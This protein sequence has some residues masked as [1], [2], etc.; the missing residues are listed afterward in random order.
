VK[1]AIVMSVLVAALM[2]PAVA[3]AFEGW[4]WTVKFAQQSLKRQ[5]VAFS[6]Q[7][8]RDLVTKALCIGIGQVW[9]NEGEIL[10]ARFRCLVNA[11]TP[12]G[13][14]QRYYIR[15]AVTGKNTFR[16]Q[17]FLGYA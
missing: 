17:K 11:I 8:G 5:G 3:Q 15:I 4:H 9:E 10:Y 12:K 14:K 13:E 16:V 7:N 6:N 2:A 1:K